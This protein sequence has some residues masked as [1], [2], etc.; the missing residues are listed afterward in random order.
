MMYNKIS[1][2]GFKFATWA[3]NK[4]DESSKKYHEEKDL[5]N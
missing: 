4:L 3:K 2:N 5:W 1:P